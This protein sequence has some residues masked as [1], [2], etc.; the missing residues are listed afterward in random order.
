[1]VKLYVVG[2][3]WKLK[4]VGFG[5]PV[6]VLVVFALAVVQVCGV[7]LPTVNVQRSEG[8]MGLVAVTVTTTPVAT[9]AIWSSWVILEAVR[10]M[11]PT[12][13]FPTLA[14]SEVVAAVNPAFV[15]HSS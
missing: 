15:V 7:V 4:S 14:V 11:V 5:V 10:P 3:S 12:V 6:A 8:P 2:S 1:M 13:F 9:P